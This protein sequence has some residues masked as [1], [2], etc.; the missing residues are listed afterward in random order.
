MTKLCS[1]IV[2]SG[3][4]LAVNYYASTD[5]CAQR[6]HNRIS[7]SPCR[8]RNSLAPGS[9]VSVV[10]NVNIINTQSVGKLAADGNFSEWKIA[11]VF[12]RTVS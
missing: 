8:S 2:K 3:I 12:Y 10:F 7:G 1:R 4:Y 9:R 5:T 11:C 6:Y